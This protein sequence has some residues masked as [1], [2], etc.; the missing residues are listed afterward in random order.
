MLYTLANGK[1]IKIPDE[2]IERLT[3]NGRRT[4]EEAIEVWLDD[5]GYTINEEQE[6]L[7][8]L[9]KKNK[10]HLGAREETKKE[11]KPRTKK[12]DESKKFIIAELLKAV[13]EFGSDINV[14][15]D[16]KYIKFTYKDE[17]FT[18]NLIKN[19]KPKK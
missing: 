9:S 8:A 7:V 6:K 14:E 2:D 15:N 17:Q 18:I 19:R 13:E 10:V 4:K 1:Q 3:R 5:E 16:E 11:R 12:V